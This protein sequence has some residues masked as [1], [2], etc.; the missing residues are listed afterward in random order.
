M[1]LKLQG[2]KVQV[3]I[4]NLITAEPGLMNHNKGQEDL[5]C[6]RNQ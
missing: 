2:D 1:T 6:Y 5:I 3:T 4:T